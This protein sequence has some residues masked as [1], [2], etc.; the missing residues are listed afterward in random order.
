MCVNHDH[1]VIQ[2]LLFQI[3]QTI[4]SICNLA[5]LA[6]RPGLRHGF[7]KHSSYWSPRD[8]L[9]IFSIYFSYMIEIKDCPTHNNLSLSQHEIIVLKAINFVKVNL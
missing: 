2:S 5:S 1:S 9:Y 8:I 7:L 4:H 3:F 6:G